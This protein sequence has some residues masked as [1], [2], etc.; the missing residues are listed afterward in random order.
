M[1][2]ASGLRP[3]QAGV[4]PNPPPVRERESARF[5]SPSRA[6]AFG[7]KPQTNPNRQRALRPQSGGATLPTN[8]VTGTESRRQPMPPRS[9]FQ[10][11]SRPYFVTSSFP[12]RKMPCTLRKSQAGNMPALRTRKCEIYRL[13][14]PWAVSSGARSVL[15]EW[16]RLF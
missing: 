14:P 5:G 12:S 3:D 8:L 13:E 10:P 15:D 16:L 1:Y 11:F 4:V 6:A 7:R 9:N 2:M